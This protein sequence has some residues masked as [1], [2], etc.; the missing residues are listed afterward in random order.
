MAN[1]EISRNNTGKMNRM[2]SIFRE[3]KMI[4]VVGLLLLAACQGEQGAAVVLP[5]APDYGSAEAWYTELE[6]GRGVDVFYVAPTCS[7]KRCVPRWNWRRIYSGIPAGFMPLITG[8]SLWSRGWRGRIR[9]RRVSRMPW[10][11]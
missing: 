7:G 1:M 6:D 11:M 8:K 4:Y 2:Y 5:E 3:C 9:W 10:Q